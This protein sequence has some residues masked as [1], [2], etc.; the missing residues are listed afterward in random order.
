M[1]S[2]GVCVLRVVWILGVANPLWNT[3]EGILMCYPISWSLTSILFLIYFVHG[4]WLKRRIRICH[5]E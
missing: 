5:G 4:G 3:L 2:T 1:I